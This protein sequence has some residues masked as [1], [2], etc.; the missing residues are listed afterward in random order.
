MDPGPGAA[1]ARDEIWT[2]QKTEAR[3]RET[4]KLVS[5]SE[6][7]PDTTQQNTKMTSIAAALVRSLP[8]PSYTGEDE[9]LPSRAQPRG[10]RI[11]G[12]G[13]LDETQVTLR[14][15]CFH[16]ITAASLEMLKILT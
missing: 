9:E 1:V 8:K 13:Q 7:Y 6:L 4:D 15:S 14:A 16:W 12:P 11:V 2:T 5:R 3:Q 10:P